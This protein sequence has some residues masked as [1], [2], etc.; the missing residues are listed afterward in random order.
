MLGPYLVSEV[1]EPWV[2]DWD[3]ADGA[4]L[5][6]TG[7]TAKLTYKVGSSGTQVSRDATLVSA[8]DGRVG[9]AWIAADFATAGWM[10][11][12]L[13][14]GNGGSQRYAQTFVC[15]VRA[16]EGGPLPAV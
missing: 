12:E 5:D 11:G 2:H 3:D 10:R 8:P 13:T 6:L 1:P 16:P 14:V 4:P 9:M 15:K 7:F